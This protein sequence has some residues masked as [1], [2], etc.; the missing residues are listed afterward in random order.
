MAHGEID[1]LGEDIE[2]RI[3]QQQ[4]ELDVWVTGAKFGEAGH[5]AKLPVGYRG[6]DPEPPRAAANSSISGKTRR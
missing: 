1:A 2:R 6:G 3:G 5:D 4:V